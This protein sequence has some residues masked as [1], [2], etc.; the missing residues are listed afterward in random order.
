MND[1]DGNPHFLAHYHT[2]NVLV[3]SI[4]RSIVTTC[5]TDSQC[6]RQYIPV[7]HTIPPIDL[8]TKTNKLLKTDSEEEFRIHHKIMFDGN[9]RAR[10]EVNLSTGGGG[11]RR[12][13]NNTNINAPGSSSSTSNKE[14][15]L[16][17]AEAQRRQR[18]EL[19]RRTQAARL[20]QR[21]TRGWLTRLH[22]LAEWLPLSPHNLTATSHCV[23]YFRAWLLPKHS[24]TTQQVLINYARES[25]LSSSSS[26]SSSLV[27]EQ[28]QAQAGTAGEEDSSMDIGS[29][30]GSRTIA[31]DTSWI[32][33]KWLIQATLREL[34]PEV[35][36]TTTTTTNDDDA[37]LQALFSLLQFYWPVLMAKKSPDDQLFLDLASCLSRW[38]RSSN[39]PNANNDSDHQGAATGD[40]GSA[41]LRSN[42]IQSL[43]QWAI[44]TSQRLPNP[45]TRA[46]LASILLASTTPTFMSLLPGDLYS[47]WVVPLAQSLD[48][49]T[50]DSDPIQQ[51]TWN[52]L[53]N[54]GKEQK[55][56][57]NLLQSDDL[58]LLSNVQQHPW[59]ILQVI[60]HVLK[61]GGDLMLLTS[62]LVRGDSLEL[63]MVES[64]STSTT[65]GLTDDNN[66][67]DDSDE[68]DYDDDEGK[69]DTTAVASTAAVA[70]S[71]AAAAA[72][73]KK[74]RPYTKL[75]RKDLLTLPKLD[76]MY[77]DSIQQQKRDCKSLTPGS[78]SI[79][80]SSATTLAIAKTLVRAPWLAWGLQLLDG[81]S[82][83]DPVEGVRASR[84]F[85]ESLGLLMQ[86]TT[87]L[88]PNTKVGVLSPL[89][90]N[91]PFMLKLWSYAAQC[92]SDN[93]ASSAHKD[94]ALS[95]FCDLFAHYLVA[96]SDVD[97]LQFHTEVDTG[98]R[99]VSAT[100]SKGIMATDII[101][102][103]RSVLHDL[104]WSRPVVVS[105]VTFQLPR[106]RLL[107][108]GTKVWNSLYERWNRLVRKKSF[109]E[110]STWWFPHLTSREG[111]GA[112]VP[113]RFRREIQHDDDSMDV[114]DDEDSDDDDGDGDGDQP[115]SAAEAET[116]ALADA[117]RDPKMAR[118]LTCI[119]QALPFGRRVKLFHSLLKADK[120]KTMQA[121]SSRRALMA[122]AGGDDDMFFDGITRERVTIR[123]AKLYDDSM[124]QLSELGPR[125][126]HRVQVSFVNQHGAE[127]A[128]IDGGG[129]FKEF[130]DDLIKDGF[131][132]RSQ[133]D[134][135]F[136]V[137]APPLFS[138][139]PLQ[140]LAVNFDLADDQRMSEH[141]EFL[142]RVLGK[143][144][145]EEILV[146]PQ[147]CL[148]F[149][150]QLLGKINSM[151][152][153]KNYDDEY[154]KN[155]NKL[156]FLNDA[157][158]E[159]LGLTFEVTVGQNATGGSASP[160]R[161][162][163]LMP[164]GRSIPVKTKAQV[165]QYM[166]GVANQLLNIQG[167]RQTKAF[168]RGFRDLIPA[169]WVRLF[170]ANELQNLISGDDSIRGIDVPSLRRA[171]S[172]LGGYHPEQPYIQEFWDIIEND[173]TPEQQRKFLRFMT[174]CSRQPL[175]GF[176]SLEPSPSIQ[177]IRLTDDELSKNSKL[178]TASTCFNLLKL[179][180]Y[181]S[182]TLLKEKLLAAIESGA[183]FELT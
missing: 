37:S 84:L 127:E 13:S 81:S 96:L 52:N 46:L 94:L 123:R 138:V 171:I 148:P 137:G 114:D 23:H 178:P 90:F 86:S 70:T 177:Q 161:T 181:K 104:Y 173:L 183:G 165:F 26:S 156:K 61:T 164:G 17:N 42:I 160:P 110:E 78:S 130:L 3:Q 6:Y 172:Y 67:D 33:Q 157:E 10:K 155:L 126:K 87:S 69:D 116:D 1:D 117:F 50:T 20:V 111:D 119:P 108:A 39:S 8:E 54:N 28:A 175:L 97:F 9:F 142:G 65:V 60:Y 170:S 68:E 45:H 22:L 93:E 77:Q 51:A 41:L 112:V 48:E 113:T 36:T 62:L 30:H 64:S 76:K 144:V 146:E 169:S 49:T 27:Q 47:T 58:K 53:Q 91:K 101:G 15:L 11:R 71:D 151:E 79:K 66:M 166:H 98:S 145:Y 19:Q 159:A 83:T 89:A 24:T 74:S 43:C 18:Q 163:E 124:Q 154:Y 149:L 57:V 125:L 139:T 7:P 85:V 182:K 16:R 120:Q 103:L 75:A 100:A 109:C 44:Q 82:T 63:S 107:L 56:L 122:M 162:V 131:A 55:I 147:F 31:G 158:V 128:G 150:N 12:R 121:A 115:M 95:V 32:S 153:L 73:A 40:S 176:G 92:P 14:A 140:T 4:D 174:S 134:E 80:S 5:S 118:I 136:A 105:D 38:I 29:S 2:S 141:Y 35:T 179:P 88:R 25:V 34:P 99:S 152:D 168:L 143:A 135:G 59:A 129:V 102:S 106:G 180:N 132:S 133:V 21:C 72:A 167:A